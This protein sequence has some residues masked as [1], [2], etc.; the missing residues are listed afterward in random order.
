[1][2]VIEIQAKTM[3]ASVND[4]DGIFGMRYNM[5][6]Y[7]GC[8]HQCIYCDSRSACYGIENFHDIQVKINALELLQKE[9]PRKRTKGTIGTGSMN[10]PYMPVEK[11][12]NLTGR[13]LELFARYGFGV[14]INT[15]SDLVLRDAD[16]LLDLAYTHASV[17]FSISTADDELGRKVEPGASLVSAR[18]QAM[19]QL[20]G[21][22]ILVGVSMMPIL[23]F[24]EDTPENITAIVER[25]MDCGARFIIPWFGM[26]LRDQQREYYYA[27]L[28]RL[29]PG[30]RQKY[31]RAYGQRYGCSARNANQLAAVFQAL[32]ER[33]HLGDRVPYY[34][35][36]GKNGQLSLF[37]LE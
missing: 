14:H 35:A 5:N 36:A 7:R 16:L 12:Y 23:P 18:Y 20:A 29:F 24:L 37:S 22:G 4:P 15:K 21:R 11:Q 30:V 28:D 8:Q 1:M 2:A 25:A 13:S 27:Q 10:D 33:Y 3:L 34:R 31:E 26:S 6:L 19:K 9:L 32:R 17:C